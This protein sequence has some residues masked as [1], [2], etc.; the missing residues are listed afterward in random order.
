MGTSHRHSIHNIIS[1]FSRKE[2]IKPYRD[3]KGPRVNTATLYAVEVPE[4]LVGPRLQKQMASAKIE[5]QENGTDSFGT[6]EE[7]SCAASTF[8]PF[9]CEVQEHFINEKEM[10]INLE[11]KE[12]MIKYIGWFQSFEPDDRGGLEECWNIVL[13]LA[14]FDFY[15]AIRK[16]SPPISAKEILGF[17]Q[18]MAE[19]SGAL[20]SIHTVVVDRQQ[21]LTGG[22][23]VA[24]VRR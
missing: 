11:N 7:V 24:K 2:K 17:W 8:P 9:I 12:G 6:G 18:T 14:D 19:I 16:E 1:P 4:E 10:F 13:E 15:T 3:G 20:A 23:H 22:K 5:R 21:Y